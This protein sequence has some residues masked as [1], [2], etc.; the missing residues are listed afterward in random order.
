M[1]GFRL[2]VMVGIPL[3]VLACVVTIALWMCFPKQFKE[4]C[5]CCPCAIKQKIKIIEVPVEKP[6]PMS[7]HETQPPPEYLEATAI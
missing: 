7:V 4:V 6:V 1:G 5:P 3:I 2:F